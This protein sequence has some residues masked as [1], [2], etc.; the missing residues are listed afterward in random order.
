MSPIDTVIFRRWWPGVLHRVRRVWYDVAVGDHK[1]IPPNTP[2]N[3]ARAW[4]RL[5][6]RR[7]DLVADTG[8]D[9]WLVELRHNATPNAVGRLLAYLQLWAD[10]D[11]LSQPHRALLVTDQEHSDV[12][13]L[14]ESMQIEYRV[15]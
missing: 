7:I 2:P 4:Q 6:Q 14:C 12:R 10:D 9:T 5:N 15:I 3:V 8:D 1:P 11:P 13:R